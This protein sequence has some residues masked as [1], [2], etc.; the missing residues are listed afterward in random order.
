MYK[1]VKIENV[2]FLPVPPIHADRQLFFQSYFSVQAVQ[3]VLFNL[4]SLLSSIL[5]P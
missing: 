4:K 5:D 3:S 2:L 1:H